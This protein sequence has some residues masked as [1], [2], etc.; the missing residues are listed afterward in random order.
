VAENETIAFMR[1]NE[2]LLVNR[3]NQVAEISSKQLHSIYNV[4]PQA[5]LVIFCAGCML[6]VDKSSTDISKRIKRSLPGV[7][8]IGGFTFGEQGRFADNVNRHGN[9]M[10]SC[11]TFGVND[12]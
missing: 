10:I 4:E 11:V 8:F 2:D 1:G 9:L 6:A 5:A 3:A 12:E 7:P